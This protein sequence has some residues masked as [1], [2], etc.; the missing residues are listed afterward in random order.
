MILTD[1]SIPPRAE[2]S[3]KLFGQ[4]A[5]CLRLLAPAIALIVAATMIP[6][7]LR[8]PSL[9]F[10]DNSFDPPDIANNII[11]YLPLGIALCRSSLRRAFFFGFCLALT[12][13]TWQLV[14][15]DRIPSF[16]DVAGNTAGSVLGYLAAE[17]FARVTGKDP[18][19]LWIS[20]PLA[21]LAIPIS[22]I[23]TI[24]LLHHPTISDLSNWNPGYHLAI[25]NELTGDRPWD[26]SVSRLTIYPFAMSPS[27]VTSIANP[28][29]TFPESPVVD[30]TAAAGSALPKGS[31]LLP[32]EEELK[33][34]ETLKRR[35]KF[36]LVIAMRTSRL[37]QTGPARIV[38]YSEDAFNR[39]FTLGQINKGLTFRLRTPASGPNGVNPALYTGWVLSANQTLLVTA[40]YDGRTS[41]LYLDGKLVGQTD[42][43]AKRPRLGRHIMSLLPGSLPI[44]EIE[45]GAAEMLLASLFALGIFALSGVPRQL[46]TRLCVGT[47]AGFVI[48][49]AVW[50]FGVSEPHLGMRILL[51]CAL[52][53]LVIAA[54]MQA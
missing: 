37:D 22:I 2:R 49:G 30:L 3:W 28:D 21:V 14:C 32:R 29:P 48:G 45:L 4:P 8:H 18:K 40:V 34:G 1:R 54:S 33:L 50:L 10:I 15:I 26:G 13:E 17:A 9:R 5:L 20:R 43:G 36:T 25:G 31:P 11:L 47:A 39:N 42:L 53:G 23:G 12:A 24:L 27:Q 35:G 16:V 52:A 7:G 38:T 46:S 6:V 41:Q 51:E 44:R 19:T